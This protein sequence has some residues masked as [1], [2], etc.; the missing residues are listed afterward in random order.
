[1]PKT[2]EFYIDGAWVAPREARDFPVIDPSTEEVCATISLGGSADTDAAVAAAKAAFPGWAATAP[3]T[4]IAAVER[5]L[6]VYTARIDE[7]ARAISQEMGAPIDLARKS[8]AT[9]GTWHMEGFLRAAKSFEWE[10]PL[11]D[12]APGER[13]LHEP[14]G[15]CALITPWNWPMN[16]VVLKVVPALLAG[17]TMVLKPSEIAPLSSLLFAEMVDAAGLPPGVF[18][19]VNG[20]GEGVGS[21]LSA[22]PDVDMV[23]FTGSTRAGRLISKAAADTI[24]RVSLELGGK[25]A[26]IIFA[27]APEKAVK[28]GVIRCFNNTGQSCNA[29][30]RMLVERSRYDQAVEEATEVAKGVT[31]GP[32]SEQGRHIGPAVS[33]VQFDKIQALIQTGI[34]EGARLVA[35]GTGRPENLNRGYYI[36][37][38]VFA[39][40]T[41]GMT[42]YREEIFGP[43]L[44]IMPFED[45]DHA[46]AIANDTEYGLTNYVQTGD[47]ER[48]RRVAR[49]LRSG[50]VEGNG[51]G[52]GQGSPFGGYKQSGNGREGG[53]FGLHEFLEV[54][55]VSGWD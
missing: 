28:Q 39:D 11:G 23:S 38:T 52:F 48:L 24:K 55:T 54:K 31:V 32:A 9:A 50:M 10:R 19:L 35:G 53:T 22:H 40:V 45:E 1:M 18:N 26:N 20:D 2:T 29:P 12:W 3:E 41:P 16:Q 6:E 7:M 4:R 47:T 46:I 27:D 14:I 13:I 42:I 17:C 51:K 36:R 33:E 43:V 37:P 49:Q 8:Q 15:V 25:G 44:S 30:T 34:D 21:Q 5:L